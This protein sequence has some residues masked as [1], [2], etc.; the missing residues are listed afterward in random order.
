M[1]ENNLVQK[2]LKKDAKSLMEKDT[3]KY[4]VES[5]SK[6]LNINFEITLQELSTND[7][8]E[9]QEICGDITKGNKASK[10][11]KFMT[12]TLLKGI[13]DPIFKDKELLDHYGV[14]T[15]A[16]LVLKMFKFGEVI[17]ISQKIN[18]LSGVVDEEKAKEIEEKIKN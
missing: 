17:E 13:K 18:D 12:H 15:P 8:M 3:C 10:N 11:K 9:I 4:K 16:E 14:V 5:L 7:F 2:L 1:A 6:K